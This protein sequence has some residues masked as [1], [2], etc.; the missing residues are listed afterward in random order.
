[1]N[2]TSVTR[3]LQ[4]VLFRMP[5]MITCTQFEDFVIDYLEGTLPASQRRQFEIHM[6]VCRE[7]REYL[8]AYKAGIQALKTG[9][10]APDLPADV[11]EDLIEAVVAARSADN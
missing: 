3:R 8:A 6:K 9:M 11:P 10:E 1:M 5:G 2:T 4:S 7:C